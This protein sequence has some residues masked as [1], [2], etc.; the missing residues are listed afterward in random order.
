MHVAMADV[1]RFRFRPVTAEHGLAQN[2]ISALLQDSRG[3]VWIG[4]QGGLHRYDGQDIKV[5]VHSPNNPSS[6][7]DN[8]ITALAEGPAGTVWVGTNNDYLVRLDMATGRFQRLLPKELDRPG[9]PGKR[10]FALRYDPGHGLWVA[11]AGGI[12]LIDPKTGQRRTILHQPASVELRTTASLAIDRAG[13][14]WAVLP[15]SLFR[16]DPTTLQTARVPGPARMTGIVCDRHGNLWVT[17]DTLYRLNPQTRA[18]APVPL[19]LADTPPSVLRRIV[20]DARDRLWI[21]TLDDGL[22]RFDPATGHAELVQANPAQDG[23]L[24]ENSIGAMMVD[25]AGLL[26]VGTFTDG[27]ATTDPDGARFSYISD[28]AAA[29]GRRL[30]SSIRALYPSG[31]GN[32]WIG[33]DTGGLAR[34]DLARDRFT[35]FNDVLAAATP[36]HL[37]VTDMQVH[38]VRQA[39]AGTLWV[40]TNYGLFRLDPTHA[41]ASWQ[42]LEVTGAPASSKAP[43]DV[44]ALASGRDGSLWVAV[45]GEGLYL[46][47]ASGKSS[48]PV[49]T[50]PDAL[51]LASI[52]CLAE[53]ARG[54]LWI[55]TLDGLLRR[56]PDGSIHHVASRPQDATT[57]SG[58]R[59]RAIVPVRDGSVWVGTHSGLDRV[60]VDA[61]GQTQVTRFGLGGDADRP[62]TV[63]GIV[64]D[65]KGRLWLSS[66]NG[67]L[68]LDPVSGTTRRYTPS[69]GLQAL[70][71]NGGAYARLP[72]GRIAFGGIRGLTLFDPGQI[73]DTTYAP[74]VVLTDA[75]A[76]SGAVDLAGLVA[77]PSLRVKASD[78]ILRLRFAALDYANPQATTY[79]FRLEGFDNQWTNS[80]NRADA[81][82][83]N[84]DPGAYVF[85]ARATNHDGQWSKH[86]LRI[87][88]TVVPAWWQGTPAKLAYLL[89]AGLVATIVWRVVKQRRLRELAY[90]KDIELREQRLQMAL[91]GSGEDF[92]DLDLTHSILRL[93]TAKRDG[94][95]GASVP[96]PL[97]QF[98][99]RI[100]HPDD[101]L[102]VE[103]RLDLHLSGEQDHFE[104]RHRVRNRETGDWRT[105]LARGKVVDRSRDGKPLRVAGTVRD[106]SREQREQHERAIASEVL[107]SMVEAVCV[108]DLAFRFV[109]V[110]RAF[111]L[112]TGYNEEEVLGRDAQVLDSAQHAPEFHQQMRQTL[113]LTGHW[114]GE[115]WQRR[116]DGEEFLCAI[117][118][119]EVLDAEGRRGH[120]VGV[121]NDNTER[122]RAE[123]ELRYLANFDTLT[124]LPNRALLSE[125]L[126][127]AIVRARRQDSMVAVLFLDLDRFKEIN[128]SL[129]HTAG[130]RILKVVASHLQA[131]TSANDTVS[132]LGGDEFTVVVEDV[133]SEEAAYQVARNILAAFARPL[134]VDERTEVTI[135]PSIGIS[136]YPAH[137]LAP[138]D[139]LKHADTAMYQAKAMGRNTYLAYTEAMETQARQRANITAALRRALDRDEFQLLYQ[140]RLSL[141]RGRI[142][143]V[144]ALLRWHSEELGEMM[145]GDF[146]PIA[147][148]TGM[149]V[150]IGE[151]A[152][153]EACKTLAAWQLDGLT[154]VRI[155][156]NVSVLQL[157]RG[158]LPQLVA[159]ILA[160]SGA[161]PSCLE[162]ELTETMI[163]AN[164]EETRSMFEQM[165]DMGLTLAIDDFGTGYSSLVYLKQLPIDMLKI[166]KAFVND[167]TKDPDDEAITTTIITMSHSLGLTVIA[168][169]VESQAQLDFLR[170]HGCD[171]IQGYWVSQP[172]SEQ[173]C[174]TFIHSWHLTKPRQ[175]GTEAT[176]TH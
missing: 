165:R 110:N 132:R 50:Q 28:P 171:E 73:H 52:E 99:R 100:L 142:S 152:L 74:P 124:G 31:D 76:G 115:M 29:H 160:E 98:R 72:D 22:L 18:L 122:K 49:A 151:W 176:S 75:S 35:W 79:S 133:A 56:E 143:G 97:K 16:I 175:A 40:A 169:G 36:E 106:V 59:V 105:V 140:P 65:A 62:D 88:V 51:N 119:A 13:A 24:P 41:H 19:E 134:I 84:L 161:P 44:R 8:F 39:G 4:T 21:S 70:E 17:A 126:A 11:S 111:T 12:D 125:R 1:R 25:R 108:V 101:A 145:P 156:V 63:Y 77:P 68:W 123:Q 102:K 144:E 96:I 61:A 5:F 3:F 90:N 158:N 159:E 141:A 48:R 149:I 92:W 86:E 112:M 139:L 120:Y 15:A 131:T 130:D 23:S 55:G 157:L 167:L 66:N 33:T 10:I 129:G 91:W 57:L 47:D 37:K 45:Q 166:D 172:L 103:E 135:T 80:G 164:A 20:V 6:L 163:M 148:E 43:Q 46:L 117:E 54:V 113:E 107:G 150:Q 26:W 58:T 170:E 154:D 2:T 71:Y 147:E 64:E 82:Y 42:P 114:S 136:L 93:S 146:I 32:L 27:V 116:K 153:R 87:P 121:L 78:G 69:D 30:A 95:A 127:R 38:A 137:G 109:S 155:A 174:R 85:H 173:H 94:R 67:L 9:D 138:T 162:L 14:T 34:Y 7:P 81:T 104:S 89:L 168:E 60:R 53:D 128:D 83:T 118:A